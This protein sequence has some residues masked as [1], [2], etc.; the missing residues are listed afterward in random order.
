VKA[1]QKRVPIRFTAHGDESNRGPYPVRAADPAREQLE[2]V[3]GS[4]FEAV[5]SGAI[6][7]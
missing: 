4:A 5:A 2:R 6:R 7:R 1:G 3:P